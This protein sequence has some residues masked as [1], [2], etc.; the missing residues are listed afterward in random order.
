MSTTFI[1]S[2]GIMDVPAPGW[3]CASPTLFRHWGEYLVK[4]VSF[5]QLVL[6]EPGDNLELSRFDLTLV[7][8]GGLYCSIHD[9]TGEAKHL[10]VSLMKRGCIAAS[11]SLEKYGS[12]LTSSSKTTCL[13]IPNGALPELLET[14]PQPDLLISEMHAYWDERHK[15]ALAMQDRKDIERIVRVLCIL[16]S[17]PGS[18]RT[19]KGVELMISKGEIR[20]LAGVQKRSASR[21]FTALETAKVL[22]SEGYKLLYFTEEQPWQNETP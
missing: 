20:N 21:A 8:S 1:G 17:H 5:S 6:L 7:V 9:H 18:A 15:E 10:L 13:I 16:S 4:M 22:H 3:L 12:T 14:I 19:N 11:T 2:T